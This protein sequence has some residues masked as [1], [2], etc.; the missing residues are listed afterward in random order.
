MLRLRDG[1]LFVQAHPS[2]RLE[3]RLEDLLCANTGGRG[4]VINELSCDRY[5]DG[6]PERPPPAF[7]LYWIGRRCSPGQKFTCHIS[8]HS[9]GAVTGYHTLK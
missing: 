5:I 7:E 2:S 1:L 4:R 9:T 8:S 3:A 6:K